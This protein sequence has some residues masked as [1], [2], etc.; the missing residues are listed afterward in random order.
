MSVTPSPST[1]MRSHPFRQRLEHL[2]AQA[3][4][5]LD[6]ERDWDLQMHDPRL[7]TRLLTQGS[8]GLGESYMDGWWDRGSV[9]GLLYQGLDADRG[10][11]VRGLPAVFNGL[12]AHLFNLQTRSRS[13]VVGKRHYD[14]GNDLY[15]A[16]LG[17]RPVYSCG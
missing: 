17:R 2:L 14:L 13:F 1:A 9:D 8:L 10:E 15:A 3:D 7:P 5:R 16:M 6:G 11:R 12:R 4:V